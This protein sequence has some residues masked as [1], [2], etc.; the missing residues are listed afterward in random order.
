MHKTK[1][2]NVLAMTSAVHLTGRFRLPKKAKSP[3]KIGYDPE[4]DTSPVLNP[5]AAFAFLT[6]ISIL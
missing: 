4:L 6:F 2:H 5:D 3:F 1:L